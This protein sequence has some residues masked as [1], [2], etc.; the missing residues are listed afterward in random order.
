MAL[1]RVDRAAVK[2]LELR[3]PKYSRQDAQVLQGQLL[4]GQIFREFSQKEREAIWLELLSIDCL[5]PSLFTFFEDVRYL[6]ACANCIKRLAM[7]PRDG[8]VAHTLT[9][10]FVDANQ[11]SGQCIIEVAESSFAVR[12]GQHADR[13]E[14]GR[15]QLWIYAMRHYQK[16]PAD[17]KQ[18]EKN[19]LIK[20]EYKRIDKTVLYEYTILAS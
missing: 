20:A 15:R 1:R 3:V 10:K 8:T 9:H 5:I 4:S 7:P 18:E 16:M 6:D 13:L 12:P 17:P 19:L 2:A 11:T 14:L